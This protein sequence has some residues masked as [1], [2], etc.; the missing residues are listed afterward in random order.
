MGDHW[1]SPRADHFFLPFTIYI[2]STV[3]D[4]T[5]YTRHHIHIRYYLLS[6][7]LPTYLHIPYRIRT[8]CIVVYRTVVEYIVLYCTVY[9]STVQYTTSVQYFYTTDPSIHSTRPVTTKKQIT[10]RWEHNFSNNF[11]YKKIK[12]LQVTVTPQ[13]KN[14][15]TK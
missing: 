7:T 6:T 5:F 15:S 14:Y 4:A 2:L 3:I 12:I 11:T 10:S 13:S 1:G 9:Y 8:Y